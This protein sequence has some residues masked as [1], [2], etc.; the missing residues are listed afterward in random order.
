MPLCQGH[1]VKRCNAIAL[2]AYVVCGVSPFGLT[3]FLCAGEW[4]LGGSSAGRLGGLTS[5]HLGRGVRAAPTRLRRLPRS[6]GFL[7]V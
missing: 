7:E 6:V 5:R 1:G 2:Q 4:N 3:S